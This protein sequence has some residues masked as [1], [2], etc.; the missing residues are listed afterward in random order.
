MA[1]RPAIVPC[2]FYEDPIA[3]MRWLERGVRV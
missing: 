3:A 1:E 2:V